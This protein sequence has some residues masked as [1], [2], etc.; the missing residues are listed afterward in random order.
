[1]SSSILYLSL[2]IV[3]LQ[4]ICKR[5]VEVSRNATLAVSR[6]L[7]TVVQRRLQA[8]ATHRKLLLTLLRVAIVKEL[9]T[10]SSILYFSLFIV[11]LQPICK[12]Y[13]EIS[14]DATLAISKFLATVCTATLI[15]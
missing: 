5:Y 14:Y 6:F 9:R 13:V 10:S 7:A 3:I 11:I 1:M 12:R 15:K 8:P 2:F 4:P